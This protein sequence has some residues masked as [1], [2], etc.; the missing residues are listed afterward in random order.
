M[1][2]PVRAPSWVHKP[3]PH[4]QVHAQI[5]KAD[6]HQDIHAS[7]KAHIQNSQTSQAF[8]AFFD[9]QINGK[10]G[11]WLDIFLP[12]SL[13]DTYSK[14]G[15]IGVSEAKNLFVVMEERDTVSWNSM[16]GGLAKAGELSD[17]RCLFDEMPERD[18]VS[19]NTIL[20]GYVNAGQMN[21]AFELFEKMPQRMLSHAVD[22]SMARM[23]FDRMPFRNLKGLAKDAIMLYDHMEEAGLKLDNSSIISILAACA[24]SGLIGLGMK[25]HAS[26]ERTRFKC[27]TPVSNALLDCMP[28]VDL[29]WDSEKN[30]VSWNATLQGL[31]MH[32]HGVK[33][34]DLFSQMVKAGF[35]P[36]KLTFIGVL[37]AC[38]HAGF[39][40][41]GPSRLQ[42]YGEG[43]R[44]YTQTCQGSFRLVHSMAMEPNAVIGGALSEDVLNHLG[45][46]DPSDSGQFS[47]LS[48]IYAAD[49]D[50]ANVANARLQMRSTGVQKPPGASPIKVDDKVREFTVFDKL[51][52]K[53]DKVYGLIDRLCLDFKQLNV[54]P[55]SVSN[56]IGG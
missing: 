46:L 34:L 12:N 15:L 42:H 35:L 55:G 28:S 9:M 31:P 6:R 33:A 23:M 47:M 16:I 37:C 48:N 29:S 39:V 8:A 4:Q 10:F 30:P 54:S 17:A 26:I 5:L 24:E 11:F 32:R 56:G 19:W 52:P 1:C 43:V 53:S 49:G 22:M 38:T 20:D 40:E 2:V 44:D 7:P 18:T 13:S 36:D 3:Q 21:E 25:V 50:W 45:R 41:E 27:S 51:H 14:C